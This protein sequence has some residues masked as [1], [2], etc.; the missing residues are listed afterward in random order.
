MTVPSSGF[1]LLA[2]LLFGLKAGL[3]VGV[4]TAAITVALIV[5]DKRHARGDGPGVRRSQLVE[6]LALESRN[7]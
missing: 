4:V 1:P 3:L 2:W 5:I 6:P 7:V